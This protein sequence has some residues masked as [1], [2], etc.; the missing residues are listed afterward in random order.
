LLNHDALDF[1]EADLRPADIRDL[2]RT[3]SRDNP[4]W[5]RH[6]FMASC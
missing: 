1:I 4:L 5:G 2:I 6:A 3:I